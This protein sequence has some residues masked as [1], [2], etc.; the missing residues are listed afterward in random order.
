VARD[1]GPEEVEGPAEM[2]DLVAKGRDQDLGPVEV[3]PG[4]EGFELAGEV[5]GGRFPEVR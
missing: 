3:H 2:G 1:L 5:K 4:P